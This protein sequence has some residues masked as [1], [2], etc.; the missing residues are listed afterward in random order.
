MRQPLSKSFA[1]AFDGIIDT[2]CDERNIK[3]HFIAMILLHI[4]YLL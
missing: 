2:V 1:H 4:I 3:I